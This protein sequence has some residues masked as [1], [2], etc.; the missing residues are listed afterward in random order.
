MSGGIAPA[1]AA[2]ARAAADAKQA[3]QAE[4]FYRFQQRDRRR[5]GEG[6]E[7]GMADAAAQM[8]HPQLL[9][10]MTVTHCLQ[11]LRRLV[12]GCRQLPHFL[13][14]ARVLSGAAE[15]LWPAFVSTSTLLSTYRRLQPASLMLLLLLPAEL[16]DL[17]HKF[18]EGRKRLAALKAARHF[19]P[20]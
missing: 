10:A 7:A 17:R 5:S 4:N 2:A 8:Q 13:L 18:E 9:L 1:A 16:M 19:R 11:L 3:K 6:G 15:A 20:N 14:V 12:A